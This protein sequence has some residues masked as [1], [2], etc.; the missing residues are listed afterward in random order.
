VFRKILLISLNRLFCV[1]CGLF[2]IFFI[3]FKL[4]IFDMPPLGPPVGLF[5]ES[6]THLGGVFQELQK[7]LQKNQKLFL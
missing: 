3:F 2:G 1:F 5:V 7:L 4:K 6:K